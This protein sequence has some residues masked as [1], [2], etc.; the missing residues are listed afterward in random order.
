V[1]DRQATGAARC[2]STGQGRQRRGRLPG[3]TLFGPDFLGLEGVRLL[4]RSHRYALQ[5]LPAPDPKSLGQNG[6][7]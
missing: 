4:D 1:A 7:I 3:A 2:K 5:S 6:S